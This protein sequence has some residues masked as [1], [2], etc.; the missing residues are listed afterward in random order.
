MTSKSEKPNRLINEKSPYLQQH[1]YNPVD[2][3]PWGE[4]AFE[5]ARAENKPIFLS[6]GYSTCHWCHVM[7]RESFEDPETATLMNDLFVNIKVDREER[8]DVDHVYMAAAQALTGQGGWPLSAWLTP[9]LKPYY[10][11]TYFPPVP[12]HGRPDFKHAMRQLYS[13]WKTENP[14]VQ[15]S[16]ESIVAA[17]RNGI[18]L[19]DVHLQ[20]STDTDPA[21]SDNTMIDLCYERLLNM[22]DATNG[23][24]GSQPKFPRPVILDFLFAYHQQSGNEQSRD[25]AVHTLRAMSSGGIYDQLGGGFAR[26]S[27]DNLWKVPHFEKM[28]YDQG[29]LLSSLTDAWILTGEAEFAST[30]RETVT[31]LE[32]DLMHDAGGF[33]SA[34]DA[35]SEGEEGT[36]YV[37]TK[38][39]IGE[40]LRDANATALVCAR[41]G[42]TEA[43][44]FEN[45]RNVLH[46]TLPI[47]D[48]AREAGID[49]A[50]ASTILQDAL[51]K[52]F[53][54]RSRRPRPHRD[55]KILT[56]WNG[57]A[58]SGL[59]RA[60]M[61]LDETR[62]IELARKTADFVLNN[63]VQDGTLYRRWKDAEVRFEGYLEDYAFLIAG[64]IDLYEATFDTAYLE[65]AD[66]LTAA[67]LRIFE[68]REGG[69][70]F[71][72]GTQ[73]PSILIRT[74]GEHDGAEPSGNS[75]MVLNLLRLGKL[76]DDADYL[77]VAD[78]TI[79]L[80][81]ARIA[82]YP[83]LMPLLMRAAMFRTEPT[84]QIILAA[85]QDDP[86]GFERLT[87]S[88]R[89]SFHPFGVLAA[90]PG[91]NPSDWMQQRMPVAS[92][93][94]PVEGKSVAYVCR[95]FVCEAP[96]TDLEGEL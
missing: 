53:D 52:L 18:E 12:M 10:V 4:E 14:R 47:E 86:E 15:K 16:A 25:M 79:R 63:L 19:S 85:S 39:Q 67:A 51:K 9:E 46:T 28:L 66:N 71:Q 89:Q 82:E 95:N 73:D 56:A 58:I 36:F 59:A 55:E 44:N 37:W 23:G 29:Q 3:F 6:I 17:V 49:T 26:Y 62:F 30:I 64:L 68:D 21:A 32:R 48:A 96:V 72:S 45:G 78:R 94:K 34:E 31:Y 35:D 22:Y 83:D 40:I 84:R 80:F 90:V 43:G 76:F 88:V 69:G 57:L 81:S 8:P 24:F 42:I 20:T 54:V 87:R 60:G 41:F 13:A 2:W 27:V 93:M 33:F 1:A 38:E 74:K 50:D 77:A 92:A 11:G 65:Q 75:V 61:A 5:K 70:F 91:E 7:E